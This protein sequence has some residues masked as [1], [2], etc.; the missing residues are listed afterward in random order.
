M[1]QY[2]NS[3][4]FLYGLQSRGMKFGLRNIRALL[5]AV[6]N[7]HQRFPSIHI[8]GTNGKGSTASFVASMFMEAGYKT[9]LYTSPHLVRFTERIRINGEEISEERLVS[10]V[11]MIRSRVEELHATFFEA[12]TCI[13]FQ[14]FADEGVDIAVVEAGLGG[15][16]DST[17]VLTPL[18]SVIT[19]VSFD[20]MEHLGNTLTKI[21]S[22]K[23]GIIKSC[24]PCVT[25]STESRVLK[26]LKRV[27]DAR[28]SRLIESRRVLSTKIAPSGNERLIVG[29]T[30]TRLKIPM[31][32]LG[33]GGE[34]QLENA[35]TAAACVNVILRKKE[36]R[37]KFPHLN[38]AAIK[39]G[40]ERV[41]KNT[42]LNG[43]FQQ[44][45]LDRRFVFDV[46]HNPEGMRTL[47]SS[48]EGGWTTNLVVVFG[49]MKD[50][51]YVSMIT[52]IARHGGKVI[53]VE[54]RTKRA[55]GAAKIV[56]LCKAEGLESYDG[57]SVA[58]GMRL[59]AHLP[60][61]KRILVTGSHYVVGEALTALSNLALRRERDHDKSL[62][63]KSK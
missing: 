36:N 7:P 53:A 20:H 5:T 23:G 43:R 10:Y 55:L 38:T 49:V 19:N 16:L 51:D 33:L 54:P 44:S 31:T 63:I 6:G 25:S 11:Q 34:H 57:G 4:R 37:Q 2:S 12:T 18:V 8:A 24:V 60:E 1:N 27:A 42:G 56:K 22:E 15:R 35:R 40:L 26:T 58:N 3:I 39:A 13:A 9:A 61:T 30:S 32:R 50:K 48:M 41:V 45:N 62:T 46:A 14:Y 29:F 28:D 52:T 17:N 59:A 21:A 47:L